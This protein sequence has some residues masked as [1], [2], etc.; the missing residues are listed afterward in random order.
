MS[1]RTRWLIAVIVIFILSSVALGISLFLYIYWYIKVRAGLQQLVQRFNLVHVDIAASHTWVV[2]TVLS[3]LVGVI[4]LGIFVIFIYNLKSYQLFRM[5]RN[6]INNFTHELKT[7]VTSLRLYLET[8]LKHDLPRKDRIHHL[9]NMLADV[10]RLNV[11]INS[12]LDLA[13]I[14]AKTY[15][16]AFI[17]TDI[18][19]TIETFSR[20]NQH[21]FQNITVTLYP[22]STICYCPLND[23]LFDML[24]MNLFTNALKYNN[25]ETP[26]LIITFKK[27]KK[28]LLIAFTDNGIG[29]RKSDRKRIFK[30]FYQ[31]G[32]AED[33]SARGNGLGLYLVSNIVRLHRGK[34]W[35]E[36]RPDVQGT[37]FKLL[38]PVKTDSANTEKDPRLE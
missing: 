32:D 29:I 14:Q 27:R 11:T 26:E 13:E 36:S 2:I 4:L 19:K 37:V 38:L 22:P 5:Q 23:H 8:F 25:S 15:A 21:L 17:D 24:L 33:R 10:N 1:S 18:V 30:K 9:D 16:G 31:T 3:I 6:F 35:V 34:I 7:P 20:K 28:K 12:I